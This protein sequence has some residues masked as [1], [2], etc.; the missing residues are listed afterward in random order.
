MNHFRNKLQRDIFASGFTNDVLLSV[1]IRTANM[2]LGFMTG[3]LV[4]RLLGPS[5][6]GE[7]A[8]IQQWG[9]FIA[10]IALMGLHDAVVYHVGKKREKARQ[11]WLVALAIDL[12]P[13]AILGALG[14]GLLPLLLKTQSV[15]TIT[16]ARWYVLGL[17]LVFNAQWISLGV[18]RGLKRLLLWNTLQFFLP[19]IG[20][21]IVLLLHWVRGKAT[22]SNLSY[23]FLISQGLIAILAITITSAFTKN[24]SH[25]D[26]S[27]GRSLIQYGRASG[28]AKFFHQLLLNGRVALL[29]MGATQTSETLG[30]FSIAISWG[31]ITR[32]INLAIASVVFPYVASARDSEKKNILKKGL[33]IS[34]TWVLLTS[35]VFMLAS[36]IAI[37]LIFGREFAPAVP[38]AM[39]MSWAGAFATLRETLSEGL[40][41]LGLPRMV[42]GAEGVGVLV[43]VVFLLIWRMSLNPTMGA[44]ASLL[45]YAA[46]FG[47]MAWAMD[48]ATQHALGK[49]LRAIIRGMRH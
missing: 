26:K 46:T 2:A 30:L 35:S 1:V 4:A 9:A 49:K 15:E 31:M 16:T 5:R 32:P 24:S 36:P 17:I 34:T 23:G 18:L 28:M 45:G 13:G 3:A 6:R 48:L 47:M 14:W 39:I 7:L 20:W 40:Q 10:T 12:I 22:V 21:L 8:I 11:Y 43:T 41:G 33:A 27:A 19:S 38:A 25:P 44:V 29:F 37:P 42:M